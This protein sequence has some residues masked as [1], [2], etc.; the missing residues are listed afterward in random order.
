[1]SQN[2]DDLML[3]ERLKGIKKKFVVLSGQGGVGNS[4]RS[5]G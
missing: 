5:R 4:M 1:M 3:K 2:D